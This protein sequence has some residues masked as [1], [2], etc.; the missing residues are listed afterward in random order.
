Q[1]RIGIVVFGWNRRNKDGIKL[2]KKTNQEFVQIPIA[3][4]KNRI[5]QL[6]EPYGIQFVETEESYTSKASFIDNDPLPVFG[7]K[8]E[9]WTPS[10]K[11]VKRGMY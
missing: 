11:R 9:G 7:S 2:G 5:E 10:G 6:C 8:P 1:H 3:R 4:L